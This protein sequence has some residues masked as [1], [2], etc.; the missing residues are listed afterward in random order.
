[1]FTSNSKPGAGPGFYQGDASAESESCGPSKADLRERSKLFAAN[2]AIHKA[3]GSLQRYS[4]SRQPHGSRPFHD[5][6]GTIPTMKPS[7][8]ERPLGVVPATS[9]FGNGRTLRS[10]Q[11]CE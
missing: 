11:L 2:S 9:I 1:M 6:P 3:A 8:E 7:M 5:L 4:Q 10:R